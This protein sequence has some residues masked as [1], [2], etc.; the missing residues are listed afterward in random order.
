MYSG[1]GPEKTVMRII[2]QVFNGDFRK[3][4][5]FNIQLKDAFEGWA[6][7]ASPKFPKK[8]N[9]DA[10]LHVYKQWFSI[11]L[12]RIKTQWLQRKLPAE[13]FDSEKLEDVEDMV[14]CL[15]RKTYDDSLMGM[16]YLD[17]SKGQLRTKDAASAKF[18]KAFKVSNTNQFSTSTHALLFL[19]AAK[20]LE[21]LSL[22]LGGKAPTTPF[23][24]S[25]LYPYFATFAAYYG[26]LDDGKRLPALLAIAKGTQTVQEQV[27]LN[28]RAFLL[29]AYATFCCN[30]PKPDLWYFCEKA[31]SIIKKIKVWMKEEEM[32][33]A[34]LAQC[35][36]AV[37]EHIAMIREELENAIMV[38]VDS[39]GGNE[40][41][42]SDSDL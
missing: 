28:D 20:A 16:L 27:S 25:E 15:S 32:N 12:S 41:S 11:Y 30:Y 2:S 36:A 13:E 17:G 8:T 3:T 5:G 40:A 9:E 24:E 31:S 1:D 19:Q 4:P 29:F 34:F 6:R 7:K 38:D 18:G 35:N 26:Q 39:E 21:P 23:S 33:T 10:L 42:G 14:V 37:V 22:M